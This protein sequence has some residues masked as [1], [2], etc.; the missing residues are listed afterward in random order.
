M[1]ARRVRDYHLR[2]AVKAGGVGDEMLAGRV[3][4]VLGDGTVATQA[5]IRAVWTDDM[6]KSTRIDRHVAHYTGQVELAD[7]I[8]EGL[9]GQGRRRAPPPPCSWGGPC[10]SPPPR[11]T[12]TPCACCRRSS[13]STTP[14][15]GTVRLRKGAEKA[16]R[17]DARHPI[18]ADGPARQEGTR[19]E[20]GR[21]MATVTCPAGPRVVHRRLLRHVRRAHRC[22]A[23]RGGRRGRRGWRA[24]GEAEVGAAAAESAP[25]VPACPGCGEPVVGRFCE[26]CG[27]DVEKGRRRPR[28]RSA[29]SSA[30]TVR[31]GS[32]WS[33]T[34]SP[35]FPAAV[36]TLSFELSGDR[37]VLGRVALARPST[38]TSPSPAARPTR[39]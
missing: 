30:P 1:G 10:S 13:T 27:Y 7:A 2:I 14:S 35:P 34:A 36:P 31:T 3:S 4:L 9:R 33:A 16:G 37:L 25:P 23:G 8:Q 15:S 17:D 6:V 20:E 5:L 38:S 12:R 29:S 18:D 19:G 39:P 32:A 28:R 11:A 22:G 24:D 21:L 26:S